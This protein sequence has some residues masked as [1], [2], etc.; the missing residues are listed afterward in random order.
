[1]TQSDAL[2]NIQADGTQHR[3]SNVT[4]T[5]N[6]D[7]STTWRVDLSN[8]PQN[9]VANL[10]FDLIGFGNSQSRATVSNVLLSNSAGTGSTGATGST[11]SSGN[12]TTIAAGGNTGATG[13]TGSI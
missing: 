7:G 12:G 10:S 2:L 3:A 6:A 5:L 8:V 11:G 9:T 1:M 4:S 13:S